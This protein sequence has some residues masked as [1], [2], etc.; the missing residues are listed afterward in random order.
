MTFRTITAKYTGT[1]RRCNGAIVPGARIRWA[2]GRNTYHLAAQCPGSD[3]AAAPA[4]AADDRAAYATGT[5][6][7]RNG[8]GEVI[9]Y[10]NRAG[11]CEDAPCCGCCS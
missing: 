11:R 6:V 8:A 2:G 7:T 3:F 10:R 4:F 5:S 1:C 9:D